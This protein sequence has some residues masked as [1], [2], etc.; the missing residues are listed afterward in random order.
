M[1][2]SVNS[3]KQLDQLFAE[4]FGRQDEYFTDRKEAVI[5]DDYDR[6]YA[7]APKKK[8]RMQRMKTQLNFNIRKF[9][10]HRYVGDG[11]QA[12][13][14]RKFNTEVNENV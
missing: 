5:E 2:N 6:P 8:S 9:T 3:F 1:T 12:V 14:K 7:Q 11:I 13:N 4:V 10:N